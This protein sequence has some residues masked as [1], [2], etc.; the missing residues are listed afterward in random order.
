[1]A[2][3]AIKRFDLP[4]FVG[5]QSML[6]GGVPPSVVRDQVEKHLLALRQLAPSPTCAQAQIDHA[7]SDCIDYIEWLNAQSPK[8]GS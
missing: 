4:I 3:T 7:V 6:R 1:M 2:E 5:Y 8:E